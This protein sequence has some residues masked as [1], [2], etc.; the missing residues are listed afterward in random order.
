MTMMEQM[1]AAQVKEKE[2]RE[3]ENKERE[4]REKQREKQRDE[5]RAAERKRHDGQ[6]AALTAQ[7]ATTLSTRPVVQ[8]AELAQVSK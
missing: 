2:D 1:K 3:R 6:I 7:L 5:E 8:E 4:E